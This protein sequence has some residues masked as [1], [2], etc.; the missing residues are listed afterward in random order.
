MKISFIIAVYRNEGAIS[1]TYEKIKSLF[2]AALAG[3]EYEI[4]FVDDGSDDGSLKEILAVKKGDPCVKAITFTR[5]FGQMAAML[6]GF[7]EAGGDAVINI[8]ADMQDPIELIPQMIQKW[9][10]GAEIVICYRTDRSDT[11]SAK[12]FSYVAY[13]ALRLSVPQIPPGGFDFVLMDRKALDEFNSIDVRNRFFQGDL[14]WTGYR[15]SF[16]P[17]VRRKRTIGKS[18]YNFAKKLKNFIDAFLDASYLPIR[19]ISSVG[20]ILS[21][22]G[23]IYSLT[24][25]YSWLRGGTPFSGW[26]PIMIAMLIIGGLI[27]V[28]LGV[29]GEYIWRIYDEVRKKPNYII[30]DKY[31]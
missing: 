9:Q 2:G 23:V 5:N 22:L 25:V 13:G 24:I 17:Y 19:F 11:I 20:I 3:L 7:K 1:G 21:I 15:T 10:E 12:L 4:I 8:S 29:I 30:R 18:Q 26:A 31:L 27:M 14:L 6:A 16:I 28:M